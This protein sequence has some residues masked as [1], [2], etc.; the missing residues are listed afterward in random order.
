MRVR[1]TR[2]AAR[3]STRAAKAAAELPTFVQPQLATLVDQAPP[4]DQ[5]LHEIKF[6]GYRTAMRVHA[7]RIRMLTRKAL[8]WTAK[9]APIAEAAARL[10]ARAA[11]ID[12][13][14]VRSGRCPRAWG[15]AGP[16]PIQSGVL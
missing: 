13:E 3:G 10:S 15:G 4:G 5:W 2:A 11:Y 6:D 9:F 14:I 1:Q 7:G 12:G 8:D 16:P